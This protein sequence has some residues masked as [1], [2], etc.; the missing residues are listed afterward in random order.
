VPN[1]RELK[2]YEPL[3]AEA[4]KLTSP[5]EPRSVRK[6]GVGVSPN[7]EDPVIAEPNGKDPTDSSP[8]ARNE[9]SVANVIPVVVGA[10]GVPL[11]S[12]QV[13]FCIHESAIVPEACGLKSEL[14]AGFVA[15]S[16]SEI[17]WIVQFP[18]PYVEL[19]ADTVGPRSNLI[20][21]WNSPSDEPVTEI[22]SA[23]PPP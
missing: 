10:I 6:F 19:S 9:G 23:P 14:L 8:L 15:V 4:C 1:V 7:V 20:T 11:P 12:T 13:S 17:D 3:A 16:C 2:R 18:A 21:L 5:P 22:P